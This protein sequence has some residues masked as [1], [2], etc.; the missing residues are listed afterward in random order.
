MP[1]HT[2]KEVSDS[3]KWDAAV[4]TESNFDKFRL[5]AANI[6]V[7]GSLWKRE[8]IVDNAIWF[9]ERLK[10][11]DNY[12]V[13]LAECYIK[14][15][16][17]I[18]EMGYCYRQ[19][20]GSTVHAR[21]KIYYWDRVTVLHLLWEDLKKRGYFERHY[22]VWEYIGIMDCFETYFTFMHK[23]DKPPAKLIKNIPK[24]C[25][26]GF[27]GWRKNPYYR[28]SVAKARRFKYYLISR[29]PVIML[30]I[31]PILERLTKTLRM[32]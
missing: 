12:W 3:Q 4:I 14:K 22:A 9:P 2:L 31:H 11:E 16:V 24:E 20:P 23:F 19:V 28:T 32:Y 21:N 6:H 15:F 27:P 10:F 17:F 18:D 8:L 1:Y 25:L 29:M 5:E 26:D 30:Y 7:C 13:N